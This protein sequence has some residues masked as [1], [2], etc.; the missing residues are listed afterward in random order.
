[1]SVDFR[2]Y[3]SSNY[4][5]SPISYDAT[6]NAR[7]DPRFNNTSA[8]PR[9]YALNSNDIAANNDWTEANK[10]L[11]NP[12]DNS[13]WQNYFSGLGDTIKNNPLAPL[14][15]IGGA[16]SGYQAYKNSR[17][18]LK[19]ANKNFDLMREQ[20]NNN[21]ARAKEAFDWQ[22]KDRASAQL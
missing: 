10:L 19:L 11:V 4:G 6:G 21:E 9:S 15:F 5:S 8:L 16:L 18:S 3:F 20:Y 12:D 7:Y 13:W 1:M 14:Q 2:Q 17:E 22:R